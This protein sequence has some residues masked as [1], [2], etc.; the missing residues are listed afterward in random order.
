MLIAQIKD[1]VVT[2]VADYQSMYPNTSF[3]SS[4]PDSDWMIQNN[5]M[6]VNVY[7]PYDPTTQKL[8]PATPYIQIDDPAQPLNWVYT[9]SVEQLTPEEIIAYQNNL[10]AKIAAQAQSLLTATDW[11]AIPSVADPAQSNPYLANQAEYINWRSK[12]RA[13]AINP[14]YDSVIPEQPKDIWQNN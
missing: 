6:Y 5:C 2:D 14:S 13:I 1:G 10:A 8:I 7:L 3:P 11:T 9:V 4:G 12:V